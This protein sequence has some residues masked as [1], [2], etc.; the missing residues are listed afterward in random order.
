MHD[1]NTPYLYFQLI[2]AHVIYT[3]P[4]REE[5]YQPAAKFDLRLVRLFTSTVL[6]VLFQ[7]ARYVVSLLLR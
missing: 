3:P 6:S 7:F 1:A 2:P 4:A 5:Q